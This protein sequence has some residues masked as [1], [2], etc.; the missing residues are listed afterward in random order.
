MPGAKLHPSYV[1][2]CQNPAPLME[3]GED[4]GLCR[5]CTMI[6]DEKLYEM[7]C[8]QYGVNWHWETVADFLYEVNDHYRQQ[9]LHH[10]VD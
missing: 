9:V 5:N 4:S 2:Q 7:R 6:Y 1:C 3:M 10:P 8:R